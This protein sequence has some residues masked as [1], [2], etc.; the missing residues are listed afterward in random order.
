LYSIFSY[1]ASVDYSVALLITVVARMQ[2]TI[3]SAIRDEA[4]ERAVATRLARSS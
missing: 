3:A 4:I 2:P 1:F